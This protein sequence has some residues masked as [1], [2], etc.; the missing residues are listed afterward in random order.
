[1]PDVIQC[2]N[3][4][5]KYR[6]PDQPPATFECR[7]CGTVLDLS[8]FQAAAAPAAAAPAHP[9]TRG[10][11][12]R[13][14]GAARAGGARAVRRGGRGAPVD[15]AGD[16][17]QVGRGRHGRQPQKSNPA[18][19][20]GSLAAMVVAVVGLAIFLSSLKD[21]DGEKTVAETPASRRGPSLPLIPGADGEDDEPGAPAPA[22][23][24]APGE[25][26]SAPG[27]PPA[28]T[29]AGAGGGDDDDLPP[30]GGRPA[31]TTAD[32]ERLPPPTGKTNYNSTRAEVQT[33]PWPR[34][35]TAEER[36]AIDEAV[37][38]AIEQ[39]G[40]DG[41]DAERYLVGMDL[42][43]AG[44]L[45]SEFKRL[46]DEYGFESPEGLSRMMVIDR[47]LRRIDGMMERFFNARE[48]LR[49]VSP[50]N[51]AERIVKRWNWWYDL[52]K[53]RVRMKPWDPRVDEAD[54]DLGD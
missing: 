8:G 52:E 16:E 21:E 34:D 15:E 53:W 31:P 36:N 4:S 30:I 25:P 43:A 5:K 26:A 32:L 54:E 29:P 19:L 41:A 39:G 20:W 45:I 24:G 37:R 47:T 2:P 12:R 42:K 13:G 44:R 35:V 48:A 9:S 50:P 11:R 28:G 46:K 10:A 22:A 7:N 17:G 23:A 18:L 1:M 3:C 40:R 6:L 51:E 38:T 14:H 49:S 27:R 33:Y